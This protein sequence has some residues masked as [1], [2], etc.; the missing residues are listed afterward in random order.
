MVVIIDNDQEWTPERSQEFAAIQAAQG[1]EAA[2][3]N[4]DT[5]HG[6]GVVEKDGV[7]TVTL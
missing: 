2:V 4:D 1:T 3:L 6:G 5:K 7:I